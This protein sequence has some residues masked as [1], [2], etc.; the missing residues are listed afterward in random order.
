MSTL[1]AVITMDRT[2]HSG[3]GGR[4]NFLVT[5]ASLKN[6]LLT[7]GKQTNNP[8]LCP[9]LYFSPCVCVSG[10]LYVWMCVIIIQFVHFLI[11][12]FSKTHT[13][14]C[15]VACLFFC[16]FI[17]LLHLMLGIFFFATLTLQLL[18]VW[19]S[20]CVFC[21]VMTLF[22]YFYNDIDSCCCSILVL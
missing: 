3:E 19:F 15:E 14:F 6:L 11:S 17:F 9:L 4:W 5:P 13:H 20:F 22:N 21:I 18:I 2:L 12:Q 8:K 7:K 16:F 10:S 1:P